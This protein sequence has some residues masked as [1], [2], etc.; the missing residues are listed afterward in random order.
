MSKLVKLSSEL[1]SELQ[2][3]KSKR[4]E[5]ASNQSK[6]N[7]FHEKVS[8]ENGLSDEEKAQLIQFYKTAIEIS[9]KEEM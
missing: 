9:Q 5:S 2:Q 1:S 4:K 6:L 7:D 8:S 3:I